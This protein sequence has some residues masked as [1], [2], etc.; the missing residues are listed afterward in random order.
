MRACLPVAALSVDVI[1]DESAKVVEAL[2]RLP[3]FISADAVSVYVSMAA[4]LQTHGILEGP[5]ICRC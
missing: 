2:S 4:E 3:V 5:R 1:K